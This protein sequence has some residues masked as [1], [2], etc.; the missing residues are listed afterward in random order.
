MVTQPKVVIYSGGKRPVEN[1]DQ[2]FLENRIA[3]Q[4]FL[5]DPSR[6]TTIVGSRGTRLTIAANSFVDTT[7]WPVK[8]SVRLYLNEVFTRSEMIL[9]GLTN[10]SEDRI[11]ESA[12][13]ILIEARTDKQRL[14]LTSPITVDLPLQAGV[15]NPLATQLFSGGVSQTSSFGAGFPI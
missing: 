9:S 11:L 4:T 13:Q 12:G 2:F 7:A 1:L 8:E 6:R 5:V 10:T 3:G 15:D 14:E